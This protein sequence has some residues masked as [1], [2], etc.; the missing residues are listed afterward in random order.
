MTWVGERDGELDAVLCS[1]GAAHRLRHQRGT[2]EAVEAHDKAVQW[3]HTTRRC[4]GGTR[5]GGGTHGKGAEWKAVET[6]KD[7]SA[8]E[9]DHNT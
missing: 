1:G 2:R 8:V 4:S 6:H 3:R 5:Q 7:N 9:T